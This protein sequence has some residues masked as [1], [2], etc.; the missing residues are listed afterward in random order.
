MSRCLTKTDASQ[1][2]AQQEP[3]DAGNVRLTDEKKKCLY[4]IRVSDA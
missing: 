3:D 1:N 2:K 4:Y